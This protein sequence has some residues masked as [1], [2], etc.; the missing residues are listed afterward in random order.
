[1]KKVIKIVLIVIAVILILG[2]IFG[3]TDYLCLK[4]DEKPIFIYQTKATENNGSLIFTEYY[5]FGYK[6]VVTDSHVEDN[7]IFMPFGIGSYAWFIGS[8]TELIPIGEEVIEKLS[9]TKSIIVKIDYSDDI[10]KIITDENQIKE[11]IGFVSHSTK[12]VGDVNL[13]GA[14][15]CLEMYDKN[16]KLVDIIEIFDT[17]ISIENTSTRYDLDVS[18]IKK[19]I[20]S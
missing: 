1:M 8:D 16:S 3:A 18:G 12:H 17:N 10:K 20:E 13:I 4:N 2:A 19:I 7:V 6:I 15:Y 9:A 11:I 14:S 5:G